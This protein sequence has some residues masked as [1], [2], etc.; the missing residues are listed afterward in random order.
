[1][2]PTSPSD[3]NAL[4]VTWLAV[5][6]HGAEMLWKGPWGCS[7]KVESHPT[8]YFPHA[9]CFKNKNH[10]LSPPHLCQTQVLGSAV[11]SRA[12]LSSCKPGWPTPSTHKAPVALPFPLSPVSRRA[13]THR[14]VPTRLRFGFTENPQPSWQ[15]GVEPSWLL[16]E[17]FA[18]VIS[19][20]VIPTAKIQSTE[21]EGFKICIHT[22]IHWLLYRIII[23]VWKCTLQIFS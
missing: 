12:L 19:S 11:I 13:P 2:Q 23:T 21:A 16:R 15:V 14:D 8:T 10:S 7:C 22:K 6:Q 9:K 4:G 20:S 1:M 17:N 3:S 18:C 5:L